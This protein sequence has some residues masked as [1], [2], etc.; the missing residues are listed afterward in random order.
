MKRLALYYI[1]IILVSVI[2]SC[3]NQNKSFDKNYL[4][5][6]SRKIK[7]SKIFNDSL[8]IVSLII[9]SND[10][11]GA[12]GIV[13]NFQKKGKDWEKPVKLIWY[14]NCSQLKDINAGIRIQGNSG[15]S[16]KS[17]I[18]NKH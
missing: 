9:D 17:L 7:S 16:G 1:S 14:K 5:D 12:N 2:L 10:L 3:N 4:A 6:I 8:E 13:S 18:N 11:Y 15:R